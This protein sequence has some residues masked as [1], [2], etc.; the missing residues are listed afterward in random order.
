M[1]VRGRRRR[2]GGG[3]GTSIE[4]IEGMGRS[5]GRGE[6]LRCR[7]GWGEGRVQQKGLRCLVGWAEG[8]VQQQ[9]ARLW[10]Q[11]RKTP[12]RIQ[13]LGEKSGMGIVDIGAAMATDTTIRDMAAE[14]EVVRAMATDTMRDMVAET[15]VERAMTIGGAPAT[16]TTTMPES[17]S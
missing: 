16:I 3:G 7:V 1:S 17:R 15:E 13:I 2:E 14:S 10:R 5:G 12:L 11:E 4:D 6:G 8:R 9:E